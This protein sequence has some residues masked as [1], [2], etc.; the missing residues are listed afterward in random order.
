MRLTRIHPLGLLVLLAHSGPSQ[1]DASTQRKA[2]HGRDLLHCVLRESQTHEDI[3]LIPL[4][5][6]AAAASSTGSH[7]YSF[8]EIGAF[9]GFTES[10][11][12]LLDKCFGWHGV[13]I[14]ASPQN[15]AQLNATHR[16]KHSVKVHSAAC[17]GTGS[18][19]VLGG[20]GTVAG[21][22]DDFARSFAKKWSNM[23]TNNCGG[24][25]CKSEVACRPLPSIIADAGFP[26]VTF[27][28]LDVEGGEER[29][30]HTV[31]W[32]LG[33]APGS[34]PF[35]VVMVEADRHNVKKNERVK[36]MLKN[37][38]MQRVAL[39]QFPGSYNQLYIRPG[40]RD[41]R[42][43]ATERQALNTRYHE[44]RV[45]KRLQGLLSTFNMSRRVQRIFAA[46]PTLVI[47]RLAQ[48][49]PHEMDLLVREAERQ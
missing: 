20:G 49:L 33:T 30:L 41:P 11:T 22:A 32:Q 21:V 14:E 24:M 19:T 18:V 40:L 25:P 6:E 17:N 26:H 27:L 35:D 31:A 48:S 36:T 2:A 38:G 45:M 23:H 43:S 4:L 10:Q 8:T 29:V 1:G 44:P 15:F 13:L 42:P 16:S 34:F 46:S 12:W 3:V 47:D 28:S 39:P 5:L 7:R 9:D 37:W